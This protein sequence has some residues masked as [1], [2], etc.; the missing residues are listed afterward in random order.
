MTVRSG[1]RGPTYPQL[2]HRTTGTQG[3][4]RSDSRA[5]T[6]G[7]KTPTSDDRDHQ[8]L[9]AQ[10]REPPDQDLTFGYPRL[11]DQ[12]GGHLLRKDDAERAQIVDDIARI[13]AAAHLRLHLLQMVTDL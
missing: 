7:T 4:A 9:A 3:L 6:A 13:A 10:Y 12:I 8:R 5:A 2:P 11:R 1:T